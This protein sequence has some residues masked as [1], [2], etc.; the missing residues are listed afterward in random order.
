M[1]MNF[2]NKDDNL[3]ENINSFENQQN[4][5]L[6][7]LDSHDISADYQEI[8]EEEEEKKDDYNENL[9]SDREDNKL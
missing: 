2:L 6:Q 8:L 9:N 5:Q 1:C 7:I 4:P 3:N